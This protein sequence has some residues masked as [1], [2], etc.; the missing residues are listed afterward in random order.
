MPA[1][2][3]TEDLACESCLDD[4]VRLFTVTSMFVYFRCE[5]CGHTWS[6][7]ER[8]RRDRPSPLKHT[9]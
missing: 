8:I 9:A 2:P 3:L 6:M 4:R 7:V 5:R 1:A